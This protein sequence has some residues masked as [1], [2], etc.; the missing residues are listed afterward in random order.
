M[1]V[2][3]SQTDEKAIRNS[4]QKSLFNRNKSIIKIRKNYLPC[5]L[6][7]LNFESQK[8]N[9][10]VFVICDSLKGKIR[11]INW[12]QSCQYSSPEINKFYLN[13]T[14]ALYKVQDELK[15]F[16]FSAGLHLKKKYRL[17]S[18]VCL[19][20]IGYP[21]W[22]VYFKR[23]G[24]YDFSVYDALSGKKEDFF[25]RDIFLAY[26]GLDGTVTV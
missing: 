11:R 4:F 9:K 16:S 2:I 19:S 10:K 24:K 8:K 17:E 23:K 26:F 22:L 25:G 20:Q 14:N 13:E 18:I 21:F 3:L 5:Y 1:K 6:F 15:W 12:P 7:E